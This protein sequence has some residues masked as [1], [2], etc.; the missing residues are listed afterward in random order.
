MSDLAVF[1]APILNG[2]DQAANK[3][4]GRLK[5]SEC[6]RVHD[7]EKEPHKGCQVE[8]T[9]KNELILEEKSHIYGIIRDV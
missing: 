3:C 7:T 5:N 9:P 6:N 2:A 1:E 8:T 4:R